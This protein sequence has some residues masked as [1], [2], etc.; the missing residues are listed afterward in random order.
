MIFEH[1]YINYLQTLSTIKFLLETHFFVFWLENRIPMRT[2]SI[3]MWVM[4]TVPTVLSVGV[5]NDV[6]LGFP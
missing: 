2:H 1:I 4:I 5:G 3:K 6:N